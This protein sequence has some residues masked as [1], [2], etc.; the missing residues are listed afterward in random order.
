MEALTLA[1]EQ[2]SLDDWF[3]SVLQSHKDKLQVDDIPLAGFVALRALDGA[4]RA[5]VAERPELLVSEDYRQHLFD[6]VMGY[7]GR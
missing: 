6:L 5:T 1:R 4:L 7:L 2:P 3:Q